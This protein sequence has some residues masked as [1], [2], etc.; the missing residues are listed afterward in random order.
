MKITIQPKD[1][2]AKVELT[3]FIEE[4]AEKLF[5]MYYKI[6]I[7]LCYSRHSGNMVGLLL[8]GVHATITG[9]LAAFA[10]PAST[11]INK[12]EFK[13]TIIDLANG[14]RIFKK[15]GTPFLTTEEQKVGT[16]IKETC[17]H[18]EPPLQSLENSMHP[19][20][21]FLIMPG[22]AWQ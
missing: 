14:I 5:R 3:D 8:S 6:I 1:F 22:F 17:G 13:Q 7:G 16:A 12:T 21:I 18:Y 4:K 11:K 15:K 9:V 10:I 20:V 2:T 19:W